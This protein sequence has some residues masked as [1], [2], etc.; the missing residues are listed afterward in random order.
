MHVLSA[1]GAVFHLSRR[2]RSDSGTRR[3]SAAGSRWKALDDGFA[4][5]GGVVW[6]RGD[7]DG[8]PSKTNDLIP[9][10]KMGR[11]KMVAATSRVCVIVHAKCP[12]DQ[13]VP[14]D[15]WLAV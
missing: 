4:Q 10:L 8:R 7:V 1:S 5:G 14:P 13:F 9:S 2:R 11:R 3:C 6:Q 12:L 15:R